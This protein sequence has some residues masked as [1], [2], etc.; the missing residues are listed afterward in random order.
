MLRIER[1]KKRLGKK[2]Y[3]RTRNGR[4]PK[5]VEGEAQSR[6]S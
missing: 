6:W 2:S 4:N 1:I 3:L 5:R